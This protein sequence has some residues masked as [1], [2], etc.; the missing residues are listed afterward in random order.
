MKV[1][2]AL[3]PW[4]VVLASTVSGVVWLETY[5]VTVVFEFIDRGG[6][7]FHRSE[8]VLVQPWWSAPAAVA[9]GVIGVGLTVWLLPDRRRL[10]R[11]FSQLFAR[12]SY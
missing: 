2:A 9:L 11:R 7:R 5:R 12:L 6:Y 1:R 4:K 8:P 3:S 10:L